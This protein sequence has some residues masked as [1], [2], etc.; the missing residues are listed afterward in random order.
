LII[1]SANLERR[2]LTKSQQAM[3]LAM[4]LPRSST[5]PRQGGPS[6]KRRR[7]CG[8]LDEALKTMEQERR[9]GQSIDQK[10]A[11]LRAGA[12]DIADMVDDE[13][14]TLEAG[15]TELRTRERRTEEAIDA[16]KFVEALGGGASDN[17][18][19]STQSPGASGYP[20]P[21]HILAVGAGERLGPGIAWRWLHGVTHPGPAHDGNSALPFV[22][23][24]MSACGRPLVALHELND[25]QTV[26][27]GD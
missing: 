12:P 21:V 3:A 7:N 1:V 17:A 14:L 13:R 4:D 18:S 10:M 23:R 22:I 26:A 8:F 19:S 11:E 2:D 25:C 16:G 24:L 27:A 6:K 15:I 5:G 9:A 20:P